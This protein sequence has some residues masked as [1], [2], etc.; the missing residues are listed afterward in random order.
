MASAFSPCM[1]TSALYR[2][3]EESPGA[4]SPQGGLWG[5]KALAFAQRHGRE[6]TLLVWLWAPAN[7]CC[8][9]H[10]MA[11]LLPQTRL[12]VLVA[13]LGKQGHAAHM[14]HSDGPLTP[15]PAFSPGS[16][17]FDSRVR[18]ADAHSWIT[19]CSLCSGVAVFPSLFPPLQWGIQTQLLWI[20]MTNRLGAWSPF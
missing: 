9:P 15:L 19:C 18:V 10:H 7:C 20:P 12:P 13:R 8:Q 4:Y 11:P 2:M 5:S 3:H 1:Y 16:S 6:S 17:P 14:S